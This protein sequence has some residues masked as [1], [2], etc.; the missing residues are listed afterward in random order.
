MLP[1]D[2]WENRPTIISMLKPMIME[3]L[4]DIRDGHTADQITENMELRDNELFR[5]MDD[6]DTLDV[7]K[8]MLR[9]LEEDE[10][11]QSKSV[12]GGSITH[13]YRPIS[14]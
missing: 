8:A 11:L 10:M 4:S 13:V 9:V 12:N 5:E 3:H 6:L 14:T 2:E 1:E 7:V